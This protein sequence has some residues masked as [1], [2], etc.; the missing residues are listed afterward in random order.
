M[1]NSPN[2]LVTQ[3]PFTPHFIPVSTLTRTDVPYLPN[4]QFH[5]LNLLLGAVL[6]QRAVLQL[7]LSLGSL[8]VRP[9]FASNPG[10]P[11]KGLG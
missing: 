11:C 10:H 1:P 7:F 5:I 9:R 8:F 3:S 2:L 4:D 6:P